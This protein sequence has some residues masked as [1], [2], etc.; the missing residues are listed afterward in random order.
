MSTIDLWTGKFGDDYHQREQTGWKDRCDLWVDA[1]DWALEI[2]YDNFSMLEVGC[3]TGENLRAIN[4]ECPGVELFG[5]EPNKLAFDIAVSDS[6]GVLLNNSFENF[7][8]KRKFDLVF[9]W[10]VLIHVHPDNLKAFMQKIVDYSN[11]Y[12]IAVEY[13][14]TEQ[15]EVKYRGNNGALW[16]ND[17]GKIYMDM[18][19]KLIDCKFYYKGLT[20]LDNVTMFVLE[21]Q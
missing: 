10:G 5:I 11:K 12:V 21:K 1:L 15:R 3:G 6:P 9:T 20:G 19:L 8:D 4:E 14:A 17:F 7:S 2:P 18:G 13:F 16:L